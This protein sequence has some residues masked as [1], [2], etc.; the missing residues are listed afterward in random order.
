MVRILLY[1]RKLIQETSSELQSSQYLK[2]YPHLAPKSQN[3]PLKT[4]QNGT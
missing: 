2:E 4:K 3:I 1:L